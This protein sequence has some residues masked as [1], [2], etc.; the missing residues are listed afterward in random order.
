[1]DDAALV[2][3]VKIPRVARKSLFFITRVCCSRP[4][5]GRPLAAAVGRLA[6]NLA[7]DSDQKSIKEER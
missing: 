6:A 3:R 5:K 4:G 1:V 7:C 2:R